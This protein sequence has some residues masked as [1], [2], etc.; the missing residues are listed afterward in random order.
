MFVN[1]S[2]GELIA[3]MIYGVSG[4]MALVCLAV[5]ARSLFIPAAVR[6]G[7][8]CGACCH[9]LVDTSTNRCPECGGLL[10]KVGVTTPALAIRLRGG[11]GWALLAW[12][13]ICGAG[14]RYAYSY[15]ESLVWQS[16]ASGPSSRSQVEQ[17]INF[18]PRFR[19]QGL[20][21]DSTP[22]PD[23]EI[24]TAIIYIED[25][26][27]GE[28]KLQEAGLV[29]RSKRA[30]AKAVLTISGPSSTFVVKGKDGATLLEGPTDSLDEAA[31]KAWFAAASLDPA[32]PRVQTGMQD[33]LHVARTAIDDPGGLDAGFSRTVANGGL[34]SNS[35]GRSSGPAPVTP[36]GALWEDRATFI[37]LGT[38]LVV[39][40]A[41]AAAIAL[42]HRRLLR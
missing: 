39:Y 1:S 33:A 42:R 31:I 3:W 20:T 15:I 6:R 34:V 24:D 30:P 13:A 27:K 12:T 21:D 4:L 28:S 32:D 26:A 38:M 17:E 40:L 14:A 25:T 36:A 37:A 19:G 7:A 8:A 5:V 18:A 9:E 22:N 2:G 10:T 35:S 23:Y 11:L 16:Q 29:L 41:G